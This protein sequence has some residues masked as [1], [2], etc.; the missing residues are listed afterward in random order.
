MNKASNS[1]DTIEKEYVVI[2]GLLLVE[3]TAKITR[4][5]T[6]INKLEY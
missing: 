1:V 2:D 6:K 5:K 3:A 4:L